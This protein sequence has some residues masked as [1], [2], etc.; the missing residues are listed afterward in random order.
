MYYRLLRTSVL[1]AYLILKPFPDNFLH[2][3]CNIISKLKQTRS[4][5][6]ILRIQIGSKEVQWKRKKQ[7]Y[8]NKKE[9]K[10]KRAIYL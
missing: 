9:K 5:M 3:N 1:Y 4:Q 10:E 2:Q 8:F 6:M 7:L